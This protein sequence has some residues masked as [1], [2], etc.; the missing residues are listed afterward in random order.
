MLRGWLKTK[1]INATLSLFAENWDQIICGAENIDHLEM[2]EGFQLKLCMC[3]LVTSSKLGLK[4]LK[5][6]VSSNRKFYLTVCS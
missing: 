4:G 6:L 5:S 3:F 1:T 2:T